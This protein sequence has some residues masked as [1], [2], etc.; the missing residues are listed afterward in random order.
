MHRKSESLHL[1]IR[2]NRKSPY[3][4]LRNSYREDGK[5]KKE[6]ICSIRGLSVEQLRTMQA[7][8]QGRL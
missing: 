8:M 5:V 2:A 1:D 7:A 4:L 3:A 6:T